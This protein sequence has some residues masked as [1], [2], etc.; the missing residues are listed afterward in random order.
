MRIIAGQWRGRRLAEPGKSGAP[1]NLR[2]TADRVRE[3]LFNVLA[4]GAFGDVL[5][6]ATVLD[7][8]AGTGALGLEAL[9]RGASQAVFVENARKSAALI[10]ENIRL[11]NAGT[12]ARLVR[13]DAT[14]L[15]AAPEPP[16]TL[17]FLD[18]PYGQGAG[19][20]ALASARRQGWIARGAVLV[21]EEA[22]PQTAPEGFA[23]LEIRRYGDTYVTFLEHR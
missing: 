8:F 11:M 3:S 20:L 18:P 19:E 14:R 17:A 5:T 13:A 2:P 21:W 23:R 4:G 7:L 6:D 15:P 22:A 10:S 16:A 1:V 12:K 9:S